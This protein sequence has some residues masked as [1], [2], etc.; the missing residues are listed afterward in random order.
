MI[1]L[2]P[3]TQVSGFR[4]QVSIHIPMSSL[5]RRYLLTK[6]VGWRESAVLLAVAWLVPFLVHA[7]P[8]VAPRPLGVYLLP[9]YW[10]TFVA[11]YFYGA[12][13][14]LAVGLV[15]PVANCLMTGY[16]SAASLGLTGLEIALFAVVAAWAV[17][18][19]P[20]F[21]FAAPLAWLVAKAG[22][23]AVQFLVPAFHYGDQP[24]RHFLRSSENAV[25]GLGLLAVIHWLL[26][27]FYPKRADETAGK[28]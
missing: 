8:S 23:I 9:I 25:A 15:A 1:C 22:V 27:A 7:I 26:V 18:R 16:P 4:F 24:I 21:W 13:P 3:I 12:L 17:G 28:R 10:T 20:R 6:S 11:L 5:A 14:G 2:R 19:W